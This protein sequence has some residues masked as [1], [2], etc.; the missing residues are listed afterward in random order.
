MLEDFSI[1]EHIRVRILATRGESARW[2]RRSFSR[3]P[4]QYDRRDESFQLCI[5]SR[6]LYNH[7][8]F[9]HGLSNNAGR[10][11]FYV[12]FEIK[13]SGN[14]LMEF[15]FYFDKTCIFLRSTSVL[16][17]ARHLVLIFDHGLFS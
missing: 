16:S 15:D 17:L 8:E 10:L 9:L 5:I 12:N 4:L 1:Y 6:L 14:F 7:L 3:R 13:S 2:R 11:P